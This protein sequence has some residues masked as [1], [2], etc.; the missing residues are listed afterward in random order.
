MVQSKMLNWFDYR[1]AL[2]N[3]M[4]RNN[5]LIIHLLHR[6]E[7]IQMDYLKYLR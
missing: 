2:P 7:N 1:G 4:I 5:V 3:L 6:N